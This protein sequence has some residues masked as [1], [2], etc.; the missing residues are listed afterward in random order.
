MSS[1][2]MSRPSTS[3]IH[4][5][6]GG[7]VSLVGWISDMASV[8]SKVWDLRTVVLITNNMNWNCLNV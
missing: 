7:K 1:E 6:I 8:R 4:A 3:K 5:R 2:L